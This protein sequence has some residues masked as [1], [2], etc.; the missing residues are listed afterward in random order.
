[1]LDEVAPPAAQLDMSQEARLAR[2]KE[3]G[4]DVNNA[5]YHGSNAKIK[6]FLKSKIGARDPGFFGSGFYFTPNKD[7][8]MDYAESAADADRRGRPNVTEAFLKL[9]KPFV[10]D[11]SDE[12]AEATRS[13]LAEIGIKRNS[14]RGD[15]ASLADN[16]ERRKFNQGLRARGYDGVII[17]DEDGVREYVVF[18]P[19]N[20]RS[21][22]A[23]FD[24]NELASPVITKAKGGAVTKKAKNNVERVLN[25]N[26]RYLG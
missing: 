4:F 21:V 6:E 12:G 11:M 10:W 26:R 9:K 18:D 16:D 1:M 17:K 25:D 23:A 8:A 14:V 3:Q 13:A 19:S 20:I 22:N 5:A 24:P 15:S 2:A 7:I